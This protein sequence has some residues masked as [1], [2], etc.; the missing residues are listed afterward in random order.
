MNLPGTALEVAAKAL[1]EGTL[2]PFTLIQSGETPAYPAWAEMDKRARQHYVRRAQ[3]ASES[4][5]FADYY[6]WCTLV[7]RT[8]SP[9]SAFAAKMGPEPKVDDDTEHMRGHRAE[10]YLV[11]HLLRVDDGVLPCAEGKSETYVPL[12]RQGG[13]AA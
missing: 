2:L 9:D 3:K 6:S 12:T 1:Y 4:P 13:D 10:Y 11:Q 7:W 8:A 5:T